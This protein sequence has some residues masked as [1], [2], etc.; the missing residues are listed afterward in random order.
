[1][2][3]FIKNYLKISDYNITYFTNGRNNITC[4]VE[5]PHPNPIPGGEREFNSIKIIIQK[6][7]I[8]FSENQK[9]LINY[10]IENSK[11]TELN[12]AT[13]YLDNRFIEFKGNYFQVMNNIESTKI[14][15]DDFIKK[16]SEKNIISCFEY[17]AKF[18]NFSEKLIIKEDKINIGK[19]FK[20][21]KELFLQA[22]KLNKNSLLTEGFSPLKNGNIKKINS[23]DNQRAEALCGQAED[24]NDIFKKIKKLKNNLI[25]IETGK[26]NFESGIIHG[27]TAF[28][29]ML[30]D[31]NINAISLID[32]EKVEYNNFIWDIVD[33]IGSLY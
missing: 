18:H 12:L 5:S 24:F 8:N 1:M 13:S 28:K 32:Y 31:K 2:K 25:I 20:S 3:N 16:A 10:L 6:E 21:V 27:D 22:E 29:N 14:S 23:Q 33:L 19:T 26:S 15:D 11:N 7:N 17:L 9:F 30:F 4:L